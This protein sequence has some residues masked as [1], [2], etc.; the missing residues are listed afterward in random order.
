[1]DI[2]YLLKHS[3]P[4]VV[5]IAEILEMDASV[6]LYSEFT[7]MTRKF[8][9][10]MKEIRSGTVDE[11]NIFMRDDKVFERVMKV[12]TE[13]EKILAVL[14]KDSGQKKSKAKEENRQVAV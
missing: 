10:D 11:N 5:A 7:E 14:K 8:I 13:G 1:M 3:D 12:L 9:K 6:E 2:T 4:K